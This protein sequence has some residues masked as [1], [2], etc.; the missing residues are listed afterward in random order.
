[1]WTDPPP[2][3]RMLFHRYVAVKSSGYWVSL[4]CA[5]VLP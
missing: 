4:N 5:A 3:P 2:H 1:M